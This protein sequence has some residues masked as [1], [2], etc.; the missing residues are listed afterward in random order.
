MDIRDTAL[1]YLTSRARTCG[2][3]EKHLRTKGFER[4]EIRE[5]LEYL[6]ER[7]YVDD[8]DY[9]L[10]YFDYAFAK[11]RGILRIKRELE[12]K[13][14]DSQTIQIALEDYEQEESEFDRAM[15]Q[16]EKIVQGKEIDERL[17]AKIG[18]KLGAMGYASHVIYQVIGKYMRD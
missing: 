7:H 11:G 1:K 18:R 4:E 13:G 8:S 14:V 10:R 9:C 17:L 3:V 6:K 5:T 2:E 12:E 16:A 15:Y